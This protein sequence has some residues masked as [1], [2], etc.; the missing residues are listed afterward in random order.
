MNLG[1][2]SRIAPRRVRGGGGKGARGRGAK[3]EEGRGA[4]EVG[5]LRGKW[6]CARSAP[7]GRSLSGP[8]SFETCSSHEVGIFPATFS[9]GV[10]FRATSSRQV[11]SV[12]DGPEMWLRIRACLAIGM[13]GAVSAPRHNAPHRAPL[14][15]PLQTCP[16][17][18]SPPPPPPARNASPCAARRLPRFAAASSPPR[19]PARPAPGRRS[20]SELSR[21]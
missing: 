1:D 16:L 18:R 9:A 17:S 10:Q 12:S 20:G 3:I 2:E 7:S 5:R 14:P 8:A 11:A 13:P 15:P 21:P 4:P 19:D 6:M